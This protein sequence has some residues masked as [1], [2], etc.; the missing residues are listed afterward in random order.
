[1]TLGTARELG[2][3]HLEVSSLRYLRLGLGL[4]TGEARKHSVS[5]GRGT[6][7]NMAILVYSDFS[8][9]SMA[10]AAAPFMTWPPKSHS[11]ASTK[12]Y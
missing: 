11:I 12:I 5:F 10:E 1:M 3:S 9:M 4:L 8:H 2:A 6:P 7:H